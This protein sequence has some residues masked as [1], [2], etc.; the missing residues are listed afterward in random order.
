MEV[1]LRQILSMI[2]KN[3]HKI[4]VGKMIFGICWLLLF[5][6]RV[7]WPWF[8]ESKVMFACQVTIK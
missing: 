8:P 2:Y 4:N 7:Q 6:S 1:I 5:P 3:I